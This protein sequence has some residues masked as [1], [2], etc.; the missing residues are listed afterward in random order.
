MQRIG[1]APLG[2]LGGLI[3]AYVL[4]LGKGFVDLPGSIR[5]LIGLALAVI[6]LVWWIRTDSQSRIVSSYADDHRRF[7]TT[8]SKIGL[9]LFALL[10][11]SA[12]IGFSWIGHGSTHLPNNFIPGLPLSDG[13]LTVFVYA[14]IYSIG[15]IGLNVLIGN[16]GQIS[17]GHSGFICVGAYSIGYFGE[18]LRIN[19]QRI[20][21]LLWV[22]I[23]GVLGAL[24]SAAVGPFAL[25]LRGN[26]LAM[27][28]LL[29]VFLAQH[30]ALNWESF[31]GGDI[32]PRNDLPGFSL[33]I[34]PGAADGSRTMLF[35]DAGEAVFFRDFFF[36]TTQSYFWL[37]WAFVGVAVIIA[38]NLLRSRQGRAMMA[39]RD[40]DLSAEVI[41]VK[42]MYTKTWAFAVAGA[43]AG[44]AGALFA[45]YFSVVQPASFGLDFS[46]LFVAMIV[47]GGVGSI[48]G[49]I[50]GAIVIAAM[51]DVI[52]LL[53]PVLAKLPGYQPDPA[54]PGMTFSVLNQ[55]I[56]GLLL[57]LFLMF[58]P[59][60]M[61]GL[62]GRL[63]R[64]LSGWPFKA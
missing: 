20:P 8:G 18:D 46:I 5:T 2:I 43:F 52:K 61:A 33:T 49:S 54:K 10:F 15:A 32:N 19:G 22:L 34:P 3:I 45:S 16:T 42:Q 21:S 51:L 48:Q 53:E 6:G 57:V 24:I 30:I 12:P 37:C 28:S 25:R 64:F 35:R 47:I 55:L 14:A 38:R 29:L 39:V 23:A 7:R 44:I 1:R 31:T 40:R 41:G 9:A 62:W 63:R 11:I 59:T 27:V 17:L 60:G 58:F 56:Y 26:Y 36:R 50:L 4:F 13:W